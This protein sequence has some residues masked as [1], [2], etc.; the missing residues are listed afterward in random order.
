[1]SLNNHK[2]QTG[3]LEVIYNGQTAPTL[4]SN[5]TFRTRA[6]VGHPAPTF[7]MKT[8]A[9]LATLESTASLEDYRGKWLILFFYPLD[10]TFVCPTEILALSN[11]Y[12]EFAEAGADILGVSTDSVFSHRAWINTPREQNGIAGLNYPL[13]SDI[14]KEVS[15][16]FG[17]LVEAEGVALRG[18]FI[19][20]PEG[21]LQYS[22]VHNLN[23]GRSVDETLRVLEAL[24][25][26][27][28]CSADWQPGDQNL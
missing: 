5:G 6:K 26:G 7:T 16:A 10:F 25:T 28:L 8:T 24:Q 12:E 9:N 1:M 19:I 21:V 18:L 14:T 23:V 3:E 13:A 2:I 27:G 20:D 17:V 22:V 4:T 11:R 15:R